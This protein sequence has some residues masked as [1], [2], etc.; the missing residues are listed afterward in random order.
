MSF[1]WVTVNGKEKKR[2]LAIVLGL[3]KI[4]QELQTMLS[5]KWP[6]VPCKGILNLIYW[7]WEIW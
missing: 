2:A 4:K 5:G 3:Q 1:H 7:Y 6:Y